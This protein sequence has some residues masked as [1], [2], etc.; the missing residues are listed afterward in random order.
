MFATTYDQIKAHYENTKP[1]RGRSADIRPA[2]K[3]RR[4][5]E[6][7]VKTERGYAYQLH[8]TDCVEFTEDGKLI[9]RTGG[10]TTVGTGKFINFY[11]SLVCGKRHNAI[12]L[13]IGSHSTM[14]VTAHDYDNPSQPADAPVNHTYKFLWVPIPAK[15]EVTFTWDSVRQKYVLDPVKIQVRTVNRKRANEA[16]KRI[17]PLLDYCKTMLKLSDGEVR[18]EDIYTKYYQDPKDILNMSEEQMPDMFYTVLRATRCNRIDWQRGIYKYQIPAVQKTI[19]DMH[20]Q[21]SPEIYDYE[22]VDPSNK[23]PTNHV[24]YT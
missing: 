21:L 12:W 10:W 24:G 2:G 5:W 9:I 7:V 18:R 22:W 17:K 14:F 1:I 11:A 16:R 6:L 19:Y 20:D 3:R 4:D 8:G 15:G 23:F 13:G